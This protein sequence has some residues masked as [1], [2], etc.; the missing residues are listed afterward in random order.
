MSDEYKQMD[1]E[2]PTRVATDQSANQ[3]LVTNRQVKSSFKFEPKF[4]FITKEI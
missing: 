4:L 2:M 1:Q 3:T